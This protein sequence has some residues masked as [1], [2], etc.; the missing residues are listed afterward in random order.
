MMKQPISSISAVAAGPLAGRAST[1]P[2][3][4]GTS[5]ADD[6]V[7]ADSSSMVSPVPAKVRNGGLAPR[8][9]GRPGRLLR[10]P[11]E[12]ERGQFGVDQSAR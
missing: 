7:R 4:A 5:L 6:R 9:A 2:G 12:G 8:P 1:C 10:R 3:W 11:V